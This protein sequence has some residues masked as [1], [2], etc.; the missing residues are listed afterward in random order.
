M[1]MANIAGFL[2]KN[3]AAYFQRSSTKR[4]IGVF[5][6]FSLTT[7]IMYSNFN[8][9]QITLRVDEVASYTIQSRATAIVTD[10]KQTDELI[11]QAERR[12]QSVYREDKYALANSKNEVNNFFNNIDNLLNASDAGDKKTK[13]ANYL[14]SV[15]RDENIKIQNNA[16]DL[17][18]Y[19]LDRP[20]QDIEQVRRTSLEVVQ[21]FM[22]KPIKEDALPNFFT[23]AEQTIDAYQFSQP[24]R[25]IMKLV[26]INSIR[27]NLIYDREA[28]DKAVEQ[29]RASV[30]PV[31]KTIKAGEVIVREGERVSQEQISILSQLG[32]LRDPN[33]PFKVL[34]SAG[35]VVLSI[36]LANMFLRRYYPE[37]YKDERMM[38]LIGIIFMLV[39]I[40]SRLMI[41]IRIPGQTEAVNALMG[42]L[43]PAAAGS[44]LVAIL[45]DNRLAYLFAMVMA[46]YVGML[47]DGSQISY[48]VV[49]FVGGTVGVYRVYRLNQMSDL[50]KSGIYI[51]VA[52]IAAIFIVVLINGQ[53]SLNLFLAGA[54][55]GVLNG[56][57]SAI[58][59]IGALPLLETAFSITSMIRLLELSNPNHE[60]LRKLLLEAP[61]TYHHSL[62][63]GN[64]AEASAEAIGA[65][66]LL[67]RVGAYYHDIGKVKRPEYFIENLRS[68]ESP[69]EKIAPAL[70]ALIITS[71]VRDGMDFAREAKLPQAISDFIEQHHGTSLAKYFYNR[72]L[73]E[74]REGTVSE[75]SFRYE[76]PKPQSKEVA[77]VMLADTVEAGI[78]SLKDPTPARIKNMVRLLIKDKF[79][80]G[81][82]ESCD[83]T[84]KD[85]ET[86]SDSFCKILEGVYHKRIEYPETIV[87][88]FEKRREKHGDHDHKPAEQSPIQ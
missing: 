59:M 81:Q 54:I 6:F 45:L 74:D 1:P 31:Q 87:K 32:M 37:I 43:A 17:A 68:F 21:T 55:I 64:L 80:D 3:I 70:S 61:G 18:Q 26:V 78:R 71:H 88:E 69:H 29:A 9:S 8:P 39:L 27:P 67:V 36:F 75:E 58:L 44:M 28:T 50:A 72:A 23:Q 60:L 76:G 52:N 38:L 86:I 2:W 65:N 82:L 56:I 35:F 20:A 30:Q 83:L 34:G 14:T 40:S 66:P 51:S 16:E 12:V 49:A 42:Y 13:L 10:E 79:N 62:M 19:I 11:Q 73:E 46:L 85:L 24:A 25:D 7:L 47:N 22:E 4:L 77:L 5:L 53:A 63:V 84:F 48:A 41:M 15:N 33:Y 57:L